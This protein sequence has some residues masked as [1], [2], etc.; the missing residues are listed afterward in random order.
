[1]SEAVCTM[2]LSSFGSLMCKFQLG[3]ITCFLINCLIV[4]FLC[5]VCHFVLCLP[6]LLKSDLRLVPS[7]YMVT[8]FIKSSSSAPKK[9][10]LSWFFVNPGFLPLRLRSGNIICF[11]FLTNTSAWCRKLSS[12]PAIEKHRVV[13][14]PALWTGLFLVRTRALR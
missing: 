1:M 3:R 4:C 9:Y 6:T 13:C 5:T 10:F 14:S 8:F 12:V 11:W 7:W 2:I